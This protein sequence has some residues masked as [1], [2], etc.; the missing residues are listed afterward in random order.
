MV[1]V[2]IAIELATRMWD[3]ASAQLLALPQDKMNVESP[4]YI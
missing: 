2:K 4:A 1:Q 3:L